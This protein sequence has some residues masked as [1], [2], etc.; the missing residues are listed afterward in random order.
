MAKDE[1]KRVKP[2]TLVEDED[3]LSALKTITDYAPVNQAYTTEALE[4]LK[5]KMDAAREKEAQAEAAA[6][7]ARDEAVAAEWGLHNGI[8][9]MRDQVVAQFGRNSNQAQKVGRKK[10]SEYRAPRRG[11]TDS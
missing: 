9:S 3:S 5:S 1:T 2:Q 4:A 7:A 8:L 10:P 6:A 11:K